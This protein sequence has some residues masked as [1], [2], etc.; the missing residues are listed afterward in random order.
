[1]EPREAMRKAVRKRLVDSATMV[2]M[3]ASTS[4]SV[5]HQQAPTTYP[6][7]RLRV[8]GAAGKAF[9]SHLTGDIYLNVYTDSV[10]Q[11]TA[12]LAS[13]Y[14]VA[15]N[16]LHNQQSSI[17]TSNIGVGWI[18]EEYVDYPQYEDEQHI[19][20]LAARYSFFGQTL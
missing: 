6:A 4:I 3:V 19:Y 7:I 13:V 9:E 12:R 1:M 2:A 15:R 17:T 20:Y 18:R 11:P 10:D 16:L 14:A 5:S 8:V